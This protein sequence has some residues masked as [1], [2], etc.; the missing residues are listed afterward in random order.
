V[1]VAEQRLVAA[2]YLSRA[3]RPEDLPDL[4]RRA[5]VEVERSVMWG[6]PEAPKVLIG[7]WG[8]LDC[9]ARL[10]VLSYYH[11]LF[12][13]FRLDEFGALWVGDDEGALPSGARVMLDTFTAAC[14]SISPIAALITTHAWFDPVEHLAEL[15]EDVIGGNAPGL[16]WDHVWLLY[17][18]SNVVD[19]LRSDL[20]EDT[21]DLVL[22]PG[23]AVLVK[24][25]DRDDL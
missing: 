8:A 10:L 3:V 6:P 14:R 20:P 13:S 9:E 23:G 12:V 25:I 11:V 7:Q 21:S 4:A 17:V 22:V 16:A 24:E 15:Q 19:R 18:R 2:F 5:G 1:A